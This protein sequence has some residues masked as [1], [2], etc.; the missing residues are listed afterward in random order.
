[1]FRN[2]S[3]SMFNTL[4]QKTNKEGVAAKTEEVRNFAT[5]SVL[6]L[7]DKEGEY[8]HWHGQRTSSFKQQEANSTW[9]SHG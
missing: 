2:T 6:T 3:E 4:R 8:Y 9:L 5:K 1:M 7:E